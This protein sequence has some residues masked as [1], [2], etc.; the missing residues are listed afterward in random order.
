MKVLISKYLGFCNGVRGAYKLAVKTASN[1][2]PTYMLGNLVHNQKVI[3]ELKGKGVISIKS[4]KEIPKGATGNL[5]IS[6]HGISPEVFEDAAKTGLTIIDTTCPW[7]KKPQTLAKQML[8]EGYHVV[9]VGDKN[10]AEVA[11]I[12][13]WAENKAEIVENVKEAKKIAFHEKI[14][15][16]AHTTQARQNFD[17]VIN[18]LTSKTNELRVCDTI[19]DATGKMQ[20]AATDIAK[21]S[22]IMLVIGDKKSANTRRL[23]ELCEE[24]GAKTYQIES[25]DDLDLNWLKGFDI[26]GVTAGAS[27]PDNVIE[28]V[29]SKLQSA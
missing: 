19:C 16:I 4:L 11:G 9:I 13:G 29:T 23:K 22:E 12:M 2:E 26:I 24:T 7:V 15:V 28:A 10:H 8:D 25:A 5:I 27:T 21:R 20:R 1:N 17:E 18:E 14:A 3:D 6:A